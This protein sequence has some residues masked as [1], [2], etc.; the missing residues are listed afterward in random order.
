MRWG[1]VP[2]AGVWLSTTRLSN[3][4]TTESGGELT[5]NV[6]NA[7]PGPYTHPQPLP[8]RQAESAGLGQGPQKAL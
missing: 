6:A 8:L 1:E 5:A 7:V 2:G 4:L 3:S